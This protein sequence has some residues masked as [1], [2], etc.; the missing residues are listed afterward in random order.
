VQKRGVDH[1][2][3]AADL[4]FRNAAHLERGYRLPCKRGEQG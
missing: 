4:L 2:R 3:Y 1:W